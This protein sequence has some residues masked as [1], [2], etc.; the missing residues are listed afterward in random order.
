[1]DEEWNHIKNTKS[2]F[3]RKQCFHKHPNTRVTTMYNNAELLAYNKMLP[4]PRC[5]PRCQDYR[6]TLTT[7]SE[8]ERKECVS[9]DNVPGNGYP[10]ER[11]P[12]RCA[13]TKRMRPD[14]LYIM[15]GNY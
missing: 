8:K 7:G 14:G 11:C 3:P 1:M 9:H 10:V 15:D 4:A 5:D 2:C 6:M 13:R 12:V